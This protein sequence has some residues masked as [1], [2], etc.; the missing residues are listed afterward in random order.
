[1]NTADYNSKGQQEQRSRTVQ[2]AMILDRSNG[3]KVSRLHVIYYS[4]LAISSEHTASIK[5]K[6]LF[7]AAC[8]DNN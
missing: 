2:A 5:P 4:S 7:R 8:S 3:K 1:M 6:Y